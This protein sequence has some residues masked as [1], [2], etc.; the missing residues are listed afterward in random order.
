[1]LE[2]IV[3][4]TVR[5]GG[6]SNTENGRYMVSVDGYEKVIEREKFNVS[7]LNAFIESL[8]EGLKDSVGTWLNKDDGNVYLDVSKGYD[9]KEKAVRIGEENEQLAIYDTVQN[10]EITL[11]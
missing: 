7:V 4:K 10:E 9:D 2:V 6:Y 11:V 5:N 8:P 1:M 3:Q